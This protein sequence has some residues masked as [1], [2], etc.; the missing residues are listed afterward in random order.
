MLPRSWLLLL[1]TDIIFPDVVKDF[2]VKDPIAFEPNRSNLRLFS[3]TEVA[4]SLGLMVGPI[5]TGS[6]SET[7]GFFYMTV[8]LGES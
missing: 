3:T 5:L 6:L 1:L 8:T 2:A 7:V 4:Y